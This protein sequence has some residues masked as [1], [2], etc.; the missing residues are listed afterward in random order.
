MGPPD[1][2]EFRVSWGYWVLPGAIF[3]SVNPAFYSSV[4]VAFGPL[5]LCV[6]WGPYMRV[7]GV[8]P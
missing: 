1:R 5:A 4:G 8:R 7:K 6:N 3:L 2:F